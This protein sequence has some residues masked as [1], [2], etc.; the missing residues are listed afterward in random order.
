MQVFKLYMSILKK[1]IG[2]AFAYVILFAVI[3]CSMAMSDKTSNGFVD[4]PLT[5][6]IYDNDNSE[7]SKKLVEYLSSQYTIEKYPETDELM[8][9]SIFYLAIDYA[10]V[11]KDGYGEKLASGE[12]DGLFENYQNPSS[13][14]RMVI[15]TELD[16]YVKCVNAYTMSGYELSKS[17]DMTA[18]ALSNEI[19]VTQET[20]SNDDVLAF[21]PVYRTFFQMLSYIVISIFINAICPVLLTINRSDLKKRMSSSAVPQSSQTM[22]IILGSL[23]S[24]VSMWLILM[25]ISIFVSGFTFNKISILVMLNS[26]VFALVAAGITMICSVIIKDKKAVNIPSNIIGLGMS[27]LGGAFVP[28]SLLSDSVLSVAKFL[29]TY[30]TVRTNDMLFGVSGEIFN[31]K[32]YLMYISIQLAFATVFFMCYMIISRI[33]YKEEGL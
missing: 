3:L 6:T 17:L 31:T 10:L 14:V 25:I 8:L 13:S 30:W 23:I 5:I 27:F 26:F 28:Q 11:I 9:D 18:D 24:F 19:E 1:N 20:F 4:A 7:A 2:V 16:E 12:T 29:P 22:Q 32:S 21:S 33:R 15:D